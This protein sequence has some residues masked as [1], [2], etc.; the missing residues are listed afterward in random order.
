MNVPVLKKRTSVWAEEARVLLVAADQADI[1]GHAVE[2]VEA[3]EGR[4]HGAARYRLVVGAER[5]ALR[6]RGLPRR[7]CACV[8][9]YPSNSTAASTMGRGL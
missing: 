7:S 9:V 1:Y 3:E 6:R 4:C 5:L 8:S 2:I